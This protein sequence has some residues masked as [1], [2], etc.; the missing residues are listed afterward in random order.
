MAERFCPCFLVSCG[1]FPSDVVNARLLAVQWFVWLTRL[2]I[3]RSA[4]TSHHEDDSGEEE[5]VMAAFYR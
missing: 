2:S 5:V 4:I 3:K 1:F